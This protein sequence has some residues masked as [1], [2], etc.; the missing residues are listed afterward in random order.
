MPLEWACLTDNEITRADVYGLWEYERIGEVSFQNRRIFIGCGTISYSQFSIT[1]SIV[2]NYECLG[3]YNIDDKNIHVTG[4]CEQDIPWDASFEILV[5]GKKL[6]LL[7]EPP[8]ETAH[9]YHDGIKF[10]RI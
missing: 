6:Q 10:N 4:T 2:G 9:Y 5:D 8:P 7:L 1:G 3:R